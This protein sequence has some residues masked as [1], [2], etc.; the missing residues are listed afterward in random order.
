MYYLKLQVV[1]SKIPAQGDFSSKSS[2][3]LDLTLVIEYLERKYWIIYIKIVEEFNIVQK[4]DH[5][6]SEVRLVKCRS[7]GRGREG[8]V[9]GWVEKFG[10]KMFGLTSHWDQQ[11][12]H[13]PWHQQLVFACFR[14]PR[15]RGAVKVGGWGLL[16]FMPTLCCCRGS[17]ICLVIGTF[18]ILETYIF[19]FT[20]RWRW[21]FKN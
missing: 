18:L 16:T 10:Q 6:Q 11:H 4:K 20:E 17:R 8:G 1:Y 14:T 7:W 2:R 13:Q 12:Q 15:E 9:Q 21:S 3:K 5:D 19:I